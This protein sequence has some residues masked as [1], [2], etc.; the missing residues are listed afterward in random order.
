MTDDDVLVFHV[1]YE[2]YP[3]R[4][5]R[6]TAVT[7]PSIRLFFDVQLGIRTPDSWSAVRRL[8]STP[9][10]QMESES[11]IL[12]HYLTLASIRYVSLTFSSGYPSLFIIQQRLHYKGPAAAGDYQD[13]PPQLPDRSVTLP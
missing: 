8:A 6:V 11:R 13:S 12:P 4:R 7:A 3:S 5:F 10:R 9:I 2:P 1:E